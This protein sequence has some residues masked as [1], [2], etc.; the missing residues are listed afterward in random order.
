M[1][2]SM[3]SILVLSALVVIGTGAVRAE[4][5]PATQGAKQEAGVDAHFDTRIDTW[6]EGVIVK[7][8]AAGSTISI[9]G[10]KMPHASV[11]AAMINDIA[12]KTSGIDATLRPA[13]ETEVR[14]SWQE[15]LDR[16]SA[17]D[18]SKDAEITCKVPAQGQILVQTEDSL[19]NLDFIHHEKGMATV[20]ATPGA[21]VVGAPLPPARNDQET[22]KADAS[23]S[24]EDKQIVA[25]GAFGQL[26]VGEP[27]YMGFASGVL[28]NEVHAIVKRTTLQPTQ[29]GKN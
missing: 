2:N 11:H 4:G 20:P 15:K 18:L 8:D 21:A 9:A 16:A 6:A 27:V 28:T 24:T 19:P 17:E 26:K 25:L 3:K 5:V 23:K 29:P 7:L 22:A 14:L 10:H 12:A 13:K 1:N